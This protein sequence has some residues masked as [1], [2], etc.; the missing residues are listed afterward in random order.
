MA[1]SPDS[2]TLMK[3]TCRTIVISAERS[4]AFVLAGGLRGSRQGAEVAELADRTC[5]G[6]R[7]LGKEIGPDRRPEPAWEGMEGHRFVDLEASVPDHA[8]RDIED[9]CQP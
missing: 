5:L 1:L 8:E 2:T 3:M 7:E 9:D 4:I 6:R